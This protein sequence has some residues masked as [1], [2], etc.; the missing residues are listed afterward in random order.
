MTGEEIIVEYSDDKYAK[1]KTLSQAFKRKGYKVSFKHV[2]GK[3]ILLFK[4]NSLFY[5]ESDY[6]YLI[7]RLITGRQ[8]RDLE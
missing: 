8:Q 4:I 7:A 2:S 6:S 5:S 3:G 1:A